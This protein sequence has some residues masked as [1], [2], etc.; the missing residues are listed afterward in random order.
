V[1]DT[2]VQ[3]GGW[4]CSTVLLQ[5]LL[6]GW[7]AV[8]PCA[9]LEAVERANPN[10]YPTR[11]PTSQADGWVHISY[12]WSYKHQKRKCIRY[13]S[14]TEPWLLRKTWQ[15]GHTQGMFLG[16]EVTPHQLFPETQPDSPMNSL[17]NILNQEASL[18]PTN[19][20]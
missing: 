7:F 5:L 9:S 2:V 17:L 1:Y 13:V 15:R 6:P 3:R 14:F 20:T 18:D 10:P 4:S 12:T 11:D 19:P 16:G 8:M